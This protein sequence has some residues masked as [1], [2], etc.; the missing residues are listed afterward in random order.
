MSTGITARAL[1]TY[2]LNHSSRVAVRQ[3]MEMERVATTTRIREGA[4][5]AARSRWGTVDE[6]EA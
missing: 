1:L 6:G 5:I 4:R 2:G 3:Q